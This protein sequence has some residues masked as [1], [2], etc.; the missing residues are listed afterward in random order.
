MAKVTVIVG[1][2]GSGKTEEVNKIIL[3]KEVMF[4]GSM[5]VLGLRQDPFYMQKLLLKAADKGKHAVIIEELWVEP[6]LFRAMLLALLV[7]GYPVGV[8]IET[9]MPEKDI[10]F[11]EYIELI[12]KSK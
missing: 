8:I 12:V 3:G 10:P 9:Q 6:D 2:Q 5:S 1:P 7:T 4:A 11:K